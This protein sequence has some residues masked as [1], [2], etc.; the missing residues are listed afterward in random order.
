[1]TGTHLPKDSMKGCCEE[2]NE[3]TY[4]LKKTSAW[5]KIICL[6][7][8]EENLA[9]KNLGKYC[10]CSFVR[11]CKYFFIYLVLHRGDSKENLVV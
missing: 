8:N 3:D 7:E 4:V 5:S 10:S 11:N 2:G 9:R 1:M 6:F